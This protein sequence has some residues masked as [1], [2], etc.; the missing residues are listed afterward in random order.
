MLV[1]FFTSQG[2]INAAADA[3]LALNLKS[4]GESD[5]DIVN[6]I[7][8]QDATL[9]S[10]AN[11]QTQ[12][13]ADALAAEQPTIDA[14]KALSTTAQAAENAASA[15]S[16]VGSGNTQITVDGVTETRDQAA[17]FGDSEND[18]MV[19]DPDNPTGPKI[20]I[21]QYNLEI[22]KNAAATGSDT[23]LI[24]TAP[25]VSQVVA[26]NGVPVAPANPST[27]S[28]TTIAQ[29]ASAPASNI[30]DQVT[31]VVNT[32]ISN[33]KSLGADIQ[34]SVTT[35]LQNAGLAATDEANSVLQS[36]GLLPATPS[37]PSTPTKPA[38]PNSSSSSST[39]TSTTT[40]PAPSVDP[41]T[42][43]Y[44]LLTG[45]KPTTNEQSVTT[46]A[47]NDAQDVASQV[48]SGIQSGIST[49]ETD[50]SSFLSKIIPS[51][52]SGSDPTKTTVEPVSTTPDTSTPSSLDA[53]GGQVPTPQP[54]SSPTGS[55]A[56]GVSPPLNSNPTL[57]EKM[58][59]KATLFMQGNG[60]YIAAGLLA[61]GGIGTMIIVTSRHN[62]KQVIVS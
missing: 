27:P 33:A 59:L 46:T 57:L 7:L 47:T 44:N 13:A 34:G 51:A 54:A 20:T 62:K 14:V 8:S 31:S 24:A 50:L 12:Q 53:G 19:F 40:A 4:Q 15:N 61:I 60:K 48:Q 23:S 28:K 22:A 11:Q 10:L 55:T 30:L 21:A 41:L 49:V 36:L 2:S 43:L 29:P 17:D 16:S 32:A 58:I 39:T 35:A 6:A 9:Q 25:N 26:I 5:A 3:G 52:T 1:N 18:A 37:T 42:A 56:A 38:T 45:T